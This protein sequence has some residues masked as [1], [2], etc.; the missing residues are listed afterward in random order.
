MSPE[1]F[2]VDREG[3]IH[4]FS[5]TDQSLVWRTLFGILLAGLTGLL[6]AK[7]LTGWLLAKLG[8]QACV[9]AIRPTVFDSHLRTLSETLPTLPGGLPMSAWTALSVGALTLLL[10][11]ALFNRSWFSPKTMRPLALL[12]YLLF[13]ALLYAGFW[14]F[15]SQLYR[16]ETAPLLTAASLGGVCAVIFLL[17][18]ERTCGNAFILLTR[19]GSLRF[20]DPLAAFGFGFI[21]GAAGAW[22]VQWLGQPI[23]VEVSAPSA[24]EIWSRS[25]SFGSDYFVGLETTLSVTW[26]LMAACGAGLLIS[27]SPSRAGFSMRGISILLAA[28]PALGLW[29]YQSF[30]TDP[31]KASLEPGAASLAEAAGLPAPG[32]DRIILVPGTQGP[33]AIAFPMA[34]QVLCLNGSETLAASPTSLGRVGAYLQKID[35]RRTPWICQANEARWAIPMR[36]LEPGLA[37]A[38]LAQSAERTG[39]MG[40]AR[41]LSRVAHMPNLQNNRDLADRLLDPS[42]YTTSGRGW[43]LLSRVAH[44]RGDL[45]RAQQLWDRAKAEGWTPKGGQERP[46]QPLPLDRKI[47]ACAKSGPQ[48]FAGRFALFQVPQPRPHKRS[49]DPLWLVAASSADERGCVSFEELPPADYQLGL[50]LPEAAGSNPDRVRVEGD[51][52]PFQL[53]GEMREQEAGTILIHSR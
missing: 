41:S 36:L 46:E 37:V 39:S 10:L 15:A 21:A 29:A 8:S 11:P 32:P 17:C 2:R 1:D 16:P 47:Y 14:A 28:L 49:F 30:D 18:S 31:G 34:V 53:S 13:T 22:I 35:G 52:G 24:V 9:E 20:T 44:W 40:A 38:A 25:P 23:P 7:G 26:A 3:K 27:F 50:L 48:P 5:A 4:T 12:R 33:Q 45:E 51:L 19:P 42:R 6:A 43:Y